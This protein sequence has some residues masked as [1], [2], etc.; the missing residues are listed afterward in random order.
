MTGFTVEYSE[1]GKTVYVIVNEGIYLHDMSMLMKQFKRHGFK[2][3]LPGDERG[4]YVF[5]QRKAK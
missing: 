4:A 2:H 1:D 5:F 3:W